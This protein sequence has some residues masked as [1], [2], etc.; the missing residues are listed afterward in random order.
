MPKPPLLFTCTHCRKPIGVALEH[1]GLAV[2]CPHC[3]KGVIAPAAPKTVESN[4]HIASSAMEQNVS[5]LRAS[6]KEA[7]E[8]ED[9]IFGE[10]AHEDE[11]ALFGLGSGKKA[12]TPEVPETATAGRKTPP[13]LSQPTQRVPGLA[14]LPPMV[15]RSAPVIDGADF[16]PFSAR[17]SKY[18]SPSNGT[19]DPVN[20]F[21]MEAALPTEF[22]EPHSVS[23]SAAN[24]RKK[25]PAELED[26]PNW[27]LWIIIGLGGYAFLMTIVAI[28]GWT[29]SPQSAPAKPD[30]NTIA[31]QKA[32][33]R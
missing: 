27:K 20:P 29:R 15:S 32:K 19:L 5:S 18:P 17:V 11:E 13:E 33:P 2:A 8:R 26:R 23:P 22:S 25:I 10:E 6:Q 14:P 24:R 31:T 9:S 30:G 21:E 1:A 28:W 16:Q 7:K 12:P 3:Q 4:I